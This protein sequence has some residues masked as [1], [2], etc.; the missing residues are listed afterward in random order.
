[1]ALFTLLAV[2]PII[3]TSTGSG[4]RRVNGLKNTLLLGLS[5]YERMLQ[6]VNTLSN[7]DSFQDGAG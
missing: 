5:K 1:M 6:A 7:P 3:T 4:W 2:F